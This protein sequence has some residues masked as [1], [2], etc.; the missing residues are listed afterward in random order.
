[1]TRGSVYLDTNVIIAIMEAPPSDAAAIQDFWKQQ[2]GRVALSFHTSELSLA[3]LLVAPYRREDRSLVHDYLR[4]FADRHTL[5]V[6]MVSR[7]ILDVA[8]VIRSG[9]KMKLPDA[10]HLATASATSCSHFLTFDE[11]FSDL[12]AD[13]H[14]FFEDIKLSPVH[15]VRPD[16]ASLAELTRTLS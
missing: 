12:S 5:A 14:P 4:L 7:A 8:A 9:R 15:I 3:E 6:H 10:I 13:S 16:S 2:L 11:G 1:M